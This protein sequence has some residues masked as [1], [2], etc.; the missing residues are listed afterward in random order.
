MLIGSKG[1]SSSHAVGERLGLEVRE[2]GSYIA[3][4]HNQ[5]LPWK[6][7]TSGR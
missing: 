4:P 6:N 2:Y 5:G 7:Y 1:A 3:I